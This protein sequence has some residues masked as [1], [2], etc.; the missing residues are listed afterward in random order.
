M[1]DPTDWS[2]IMRIDKSLWYYPQNCKRS[3]NHTV[4][5][6]RRIHNEVVWVTYLEK[7]NYYIAGIMIKW[8]RINLWTYY[9]FQ[10]AADARR[11]A[12][13]KYLWKYIEY[14]SSDCL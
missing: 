14:S 8:K 6:N 5:A 2:N 10:D 9:N 12:E 1:W 11:E 13:L 7:K 3:C 4:A